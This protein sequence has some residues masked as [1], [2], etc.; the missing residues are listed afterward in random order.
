[1]S[2]LHLPLLLTL[3]RRKTFLWVLRPSVSTSCLAELK[4]SCYG[5]KCKYQRDV[6]RR[7]YPPVPWVERHNIFFSSS[8][9]VRFLQMLIYSFLTWLTV[10]M[11]NFP[12]KSFG[13]VKENIRRSILFE[14]LS[15][16]AITH[17]TFP[18]TGSSSCMLL[19]VYLSGKVI[20]STIKPLILIEFVDKQDS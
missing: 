6:W 20:R 15:F 1:M 12:N 2:S 16:A 14:S 19:Y 5:G 11:E 9:N 4:W 3:L 13:I 10:Q 8:Q 18:H 7:T 17:P